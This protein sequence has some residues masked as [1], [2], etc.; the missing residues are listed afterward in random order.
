MA[1]K[2]NTVKLERHNPKWREDFEVQKK[3]LAKILGDNLIGIHHIGSTAISN[4]SAKPIID[5]A[6]EI[7]N[8]SALDQ[9]DNKLKEKGFIYRSMHDKPGYRLYIKGGKDY[10]SCHIHFY[11]KG[12]ETLQND[13]HFRDYLV[14]HP[15]TAKK[16]DELKQNLADKYPNDRKKYTEG[17]KGFIEAVLAKL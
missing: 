15:E 10:R 5:I 16:Y 9:L 8:F 1:L 4:I 3:L 13:L 14:N 11:E 2:R 6:V 12:S 17:K 7:N